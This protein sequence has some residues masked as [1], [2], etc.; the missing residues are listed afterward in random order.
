MLQRYKSEKNRELA[1]SIYILRQQGTSYH[2][3]AR[4][5][6]MKYSNVVNIYRRECQFRELA[7]AMPFAEYI[8]PRIKNALRKQFG[9]NLLADPRNF[10]KPELL[11]RLFL[12]P[13]VGEKALQSLA[14]ALSE[15][16]YEAFSLEEIKKQIYQ[17]KARNFS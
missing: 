10:C 2:E 16:G 3:I 7:F 9:L 14:D 12:F 6:N 17:K 11:R 15:A 1:E 4:R 8:P 5:M 13:G